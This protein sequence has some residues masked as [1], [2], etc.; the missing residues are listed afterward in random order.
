MTNNSRT[1]RIAISA[2]PSGQFTL[3]QDADG[4]FV[5]R[6]GKGLVQGYYPASEAD[7]A[8]AVL[9]DRNA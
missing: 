6:D 2:K 4:N 9:D 3:S 7:F 8:Y 1:A 5:L